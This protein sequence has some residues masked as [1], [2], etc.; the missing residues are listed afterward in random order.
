MPRY[1]E[2]DFGR[3]TPRGPRQFGQPQG[4]MP[5]GGDQGIPD[6]SPGGQTG[7]PRFV[8]RGPEQFGLGQGA[9]PTAGNQRTP[10]DEVLGRARFA[11]RGP[12]RFGQQTGVEN[13]GGR[14]TSRPQFR[15]NSRGGNYSEGR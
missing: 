4:G 15:V 7:G 6:T 11:P 1:D 2:E 5:A 12:Q 14:R 13:R 9:Y 10:G 3:F 8:P